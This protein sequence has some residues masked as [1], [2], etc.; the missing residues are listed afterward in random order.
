MAKITYD[1]ALGPNGALADFFDAALILQDKKSDD[2]KV[3]FKDTGDGN[4]KVTFTGSGFEW[5]DGQ[6][7]LGAGT[8]NG[9]KFAT[10]TGDATYM[11]FTGLDLEVGEFN[12]AYFA[13]NDIQDVI[14][15]LVS[16]NDTITG[17]KI[18][19]TIAA[20]DG[21]DN[22]H[23]GVGNDHVDGGAK[24]DKLWGDAGND[25][26]WGNTGNDRMWG[27][28]GSDKFQF[29]EGD[30]NDVIVDFDAIGGGKQQDYL[31]LDDG[32]TFT[33]KKSGHDLILDFGDGD[34]LT[35]LDVKRSDFS[36]T[37]DID[38]ILPA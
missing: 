26:L 10:Q 6:D 27:N 37:A 33:I 8:I 34:T 3:V 15:L 24:A 17:S 9:I 7:V 1:T 18:A 22:V 36:K 11:T 19:D 23:A 38:W 12:G 14:D 30:G 31:S 21:K 35:L 32:D 28:A 13:N 29:H 25:D 16:G 5:Q 2:E 20:G 4:D